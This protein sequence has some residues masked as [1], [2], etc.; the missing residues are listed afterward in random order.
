[1]HSAG[2]IIF[3]IYRVFLNKSKDQVYLYHSQMKIM[4]SHQK[5]SLKNQQNFKKQKTKKLEKNQM[6]NLKD[7]QKILNKL[8]NQ[9]S[10]KKKSKKA[11]QNN[12]K[13]NKPQKQKKSKKKI[14]T[15]YQKWISALVK[16]FGLKKT[17]HPISFIMRKQTLAMVKLEKSAVDFNSVFPQNKCRGQWQLLLQTCVRESQLIGILMAWFYVHRPLKVKMYNF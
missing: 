17:H 3:N 2:W 7:P 6:N 5:L 14:F 10:K 15:N 4:Q 13:N 8:N 1:M 16:L 11:N 9:H 12:S